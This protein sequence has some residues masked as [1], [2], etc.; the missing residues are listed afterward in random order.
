MTKH[1]RARCTAKLIAAVENSEHTIS[2][3]AEQHK[4]HP[5][6]LSALLHGMPAGPSK[7]TRLLALAK[8]LGVKPEDALRA[9]V[10]TTT[11]FRNRDRN[12]R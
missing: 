12:A 2:A 10:Q 1:T 9:C 3:L 5:A 6:Q 7:Q 4:F 11:G 8:H